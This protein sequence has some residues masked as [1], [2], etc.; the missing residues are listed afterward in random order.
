[1]KDVEFFYYMEEAIQERLSNSENIYVKAVPVHKNND[2]ILYGLRIIRENEPNIPAPLVYLNG[3]YEEYRQGR[4]LESITNEIA[5]I[6]ESNPWNQ[7][8]KLSLRYEDI[9]DRIFYEVVG[10]EANRKNFRELLHTDIGNGLSFVY[11][12]QHLTDENDVC[13]SI[14]I[15]HNLI[16]SFHYDV[17]RLKEDALHNTPQLFPEEMTTLSDAD[18]R[19]AIDFTKRC[20][21]QTF[22]YVLSN[23]EKINGATVLFYPDMQKRLAEYLGNNYY[24]LPSSVHEVIIMP[25]WYGMTVEKMEQ[26]VRSVNCKCVKSEDVLL[27]KVLYY[28]REK[29]Q[30]RL[31]TPDIPQL[32]KKE[33]EKE[34]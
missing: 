11:R 31:A 12:I 17:S 2:V 14:K 10:T 15:T 28:D 30:L 16:R 1:M 20:T 27:N 25:E 19:G 6:Y 18:N 4:D 23:T 21:N 7:K 29:E 8:L 24:V 34:R 32:S 33:Q 3:F 5:Q 26:I 22:A 9:Q 13:A